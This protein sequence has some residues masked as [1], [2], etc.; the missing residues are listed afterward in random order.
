VATGTRLRPGTVYGTLSDALL[1]NSGGAVTMNSVGL[2][3]AFVPTITTQYMPVILDPQQQN[4]APEIV[5][6]TAHAGGATTATV[7][8]Q[9]EGSALRAHLSGEFWVAGPTPQDYFPWNWTAY[10]PTWTASTTNPS[11]GNGS[12][13]GFYTLF[14]TTCNFQIYILFGSMTNGGLGVWSLTLPPGVTS[15]ANQVQGV[16]TFLFTTGGSSLLWGAQAVLTSSVT[17]F[18]VY[19]PSSATA[20]NWNAVQNT[21]SGGA[22]GLGIPNTGNNYPFITN[23]YLSINGSF[24]T[25]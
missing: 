17:S 16:P 25:A 1:T 12:M 10:T 23:A 4:G 2:G 8:R 7:L 24:Q 22:A 20:S 15:A 3:T 9:Q 21:N 11:I 19:A 5:W 14:G 13:V 6:V 18:S